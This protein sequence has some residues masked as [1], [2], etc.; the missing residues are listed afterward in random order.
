MSL[1]CADTVLAWIAPP[2]SI[3]MEFR[4]L[5]GHDRSDKWACRSSGLTRDPE[6]CSFYHHNKYI[7]PSASQAFLGAL[8]FSLVSLLNVVR[9]ILSPLTGFIVTVG[10]PIIAACEGRQT[11]WSDLFKPLLMPFAALLCLMKSFVAIFTALVGNLCCSSHE[12]PQAEA[13]GPDVGGEVV[14]LINRRF[15]QA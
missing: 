11:D 9:L 15:P 7:E 6:L 1:G 12:R 13:V 10:A 8:A 14:N 5:S 4:H 2:L 3:S